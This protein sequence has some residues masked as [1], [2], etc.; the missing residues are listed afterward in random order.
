[1]GGILG[2]SASERERKCDRA[3]GERGR[4]DAS[5]WGGRD[6][7]IMTSSGRSG[8]GEVDS[9]AVSGGGAATVESR[10]STD[11]TGLGRGVNRSDDILDDSRNG[12]WG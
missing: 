11:S 2:T 4:D 10:E 1:M 8:F 7:V 3:N 12:L 6:K 5:G 9:V